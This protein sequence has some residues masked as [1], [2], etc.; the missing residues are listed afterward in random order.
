MTI[1]VSLKACVTMNAAT[2]RGR[3]TFCRWTFGTGW[4]TPAAGGCH[5]RSLKPAID[6][7]P[8][9]DGGRRGGG[10][11]RGRDVARLR[12]TLTLTLTGTDQVVT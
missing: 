12:A 10:A 3:V 9:L 1:L 4:A 11:D 2:V 6:A 7:R 8:P 5:G